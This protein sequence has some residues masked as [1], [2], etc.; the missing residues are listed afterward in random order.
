VKQ[1][2]EEW[3]KIINENRN[4]ER[5]SLPAAAPLRGFLRS[6]PKISDLD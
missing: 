6:D 2:F 4:N 1:A 5:N 3:G